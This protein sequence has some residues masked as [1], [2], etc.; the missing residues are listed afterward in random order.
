MAQI[1]SWWNK[2]KIREKGTILSY[3][4]EP[5]L[6]KRSLD[7]EIRLHTCVTSLSVRHY[8]CRNLG[9]S[10]FRQTLTLQLG[11]GHG[12][13]LETNFESDRAFYANAAAIVWFSLISVGI[14]SRNRAAE[15]QWWKR[16]NPLSWCFIITDSYKNDLEGDLIRSRV[17]VYRYHLEPESSS[18]P[19]PKLDKSTTFACGKAVLEAAVAVWFELLP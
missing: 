6:S 14:A 11:T 9:D 1:H 19:E 15:K 18:D 12:T 7:R 16:V 17:A 3:N 10:C 13:K 2:K 4:S 5:Y 8:F